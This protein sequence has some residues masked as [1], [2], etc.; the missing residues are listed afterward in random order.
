VLSLVLSLTIGL[1]NVSSAG[2]RWAI[3]KSLGVRHDAPLSD[4]NTGMSAVQ[5][6]PRSGATL[7]RPAAHRSQPL[8]ERS[9]AIEVPLRKLADKTGLICRR[10]HCAKQKH[11]FGG[12]RVSASRLNDARQA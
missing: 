5:P 4:P 7:T 9:L 12:A 1:N 6:L 11:I 2:V 8:P 10:S 3:F